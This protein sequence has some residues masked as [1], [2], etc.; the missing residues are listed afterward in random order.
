MASYVQ[1]HIYQASPNGWGKHHSLIYTIPVPLPVVEKKGR[2]QETLTQE[3]SADEKVGIT[4][5]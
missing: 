5:L 4:K 1:I 2:Q 3:V